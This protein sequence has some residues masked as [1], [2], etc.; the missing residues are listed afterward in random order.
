MLRIKIIKEII[1]ELFKAYLVN[2]KL[3]ITI[4]NVK[5]DES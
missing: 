3:I 1:D 2:G 4:F 5:L